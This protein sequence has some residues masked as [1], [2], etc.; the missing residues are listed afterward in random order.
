[1]VRVGYGS[2]WFLA[3]VCASLLHGN[4]DVCAIAD[5]LLHSSP[6]NEMSTTIYGMGPTGADRALTFGLSG[7]PTLRL[8]GGVARKAG[9]KSF[10]DASGARIDVGEDGVSLFTAPARTF[11]S[12]LVTNGEGE[13]GRGRGRG[14][15]EKERECNGSASGARY[16]LS[17]LRIV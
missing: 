6:I 7:T 15:G 14:R 1:M 3:C 9:L 16:A 17:M 13:G 11:S 4:S 8:R 2:R 12:C 5:T 10:V